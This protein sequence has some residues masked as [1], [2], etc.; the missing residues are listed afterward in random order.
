MVEKPSEF[1]KS[2]PVTAHCPI[3][4]AERKCDVH[5]NVYKSWSWEVNGGRNSMD[6]GVN[7]SLLECRGC[8]TVFY[9]RDSWDSE[10]VDYYYGPEGE[11]LVEPVRDKHTY[12]PPDSQTK[13][14]WFDALG[15]VDGQ[16]Q[17]ILNE[18]YVTYDH[19]AYILTAVGLRTALDRATE[20]LGIDPAISFEEKLKELKD[21]GW[22]GETEHSI[23]D[24][25][26]NA[27][28]AAAHRGW[29]PSNDDAGKLL[30]AMEAFLYRAFIVGQDALSIKANIPPKPKRKLAKATVRST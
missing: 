26:T 29:S 15:K 28:S 22:V 24:V 2:D 16:L 17:S 11:T 18:M 19:K 23:L 3:C 1:K 21:G 20:V 14:L 13:P 4:N 6:G 25:I 8:E 5:A 10:N 7:H 9:L 27:G 30:T 12:P